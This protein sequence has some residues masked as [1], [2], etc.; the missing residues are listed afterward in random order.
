MYGAILVCHLLELVSLQCRL[1]FGTLRDLRLHPSKCLGIILAWLIHLRHVGITHPLRVCLVAPSVCVSRLVLSN[2]IFARCNRLRQFVVVSR[3]G[4]FLRIG[5]AVRCLA[6]CLVY[7][8]T[9]LVKNDT[10]DVSHCGVFAL[11]CIL[12]GGSLYLFYPPLFCG[13]HLLWV[14]MCQP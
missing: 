9:I 2:G 13:G 11:R 4:C 6:Q 7:I 8:N 1:I 12:V 5:A 14:F 10:L 3:Y